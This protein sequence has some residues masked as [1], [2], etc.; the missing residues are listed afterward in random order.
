M[1]SIIIPTWNNLA[2]LK[3]CVESIRQYSVP[4]HQIIIHINDGSDGTLAWVKAEG[5]FYTHSAENEGVCVAMNKASTLAEKDYILFVNDDMFVLPG[6]DEIL[7]E[8]I[9]KLNTD[10]FMLS[11]TMIEPYDTRNKCVIVADYGRNDKNFERDKLLQTFN[12]YKKENWSGSTWPPCVVHKK[13]W[14]AVG[15]YSEEFSPGMSSDD[16]FS[17]KMWQAGC[18]IYKGVGA[19]R[20]YHFISQSTGRVIKNNG[21]R[22]FLKKWGIKQTTY[23]KYFIHRGKPYNGQLKEPGNSIAYTAQKMLDRL[24]DRL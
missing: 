18:R 8:E 21:R 11:G 6:W 10:C 22:Q 5:L 7:M 20:V 15:G 16:D 3:L 23:H 9:T 14:N 12:S 1:F 17:M 2:F 13:W 4:G 24:F 19:S